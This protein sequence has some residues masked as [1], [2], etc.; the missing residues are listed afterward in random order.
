VGPTANPGAT[1]HGKYQTVVVPAATLSDEVIGKMADLYLSNFDGSSTAIFRED[2]AE[3]DEVLLVYQEDEL[4]GFTTLKILQFRHAG[5]QARA[6]YSG[7]TIVA[8]QHWGQQVLAFAWIAHV[9]EIKRQAPHLPLFWFLLVKGHR[10]FRYL[11]VFSKS[12]FP[13]WAE[14]RADLK[15]LADHL[16]AAKFG[17]HYDPVSGLVRFPESR[18]HLRREIAE[19]SAEE[20]EKPATR[21]FLEKNP[22]Y[23]LGHELVCICELETF[24][25]KPLTARIFSKAAKE[26]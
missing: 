21:F 6:V 4:V 15:I 18:G 25:M 2:L 8:P 13:H 11:S 9:G 7:D 24:N 12:F 20:R 10:T 19:P 14:D 1:H 17:S 23:R 3:K 26:R 22:G 5:N 16:A